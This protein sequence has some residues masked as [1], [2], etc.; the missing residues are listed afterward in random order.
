MAA[1]ERYTAQKVSYILRHNT[2]ENP[3]PSSNIDIDPTRSPLND[4]L[5]PERGT[6]A[7]E[8]KDYYNQRLN[9]IYHM[10]R[11]DIITTCQW[12][13]TA[14]ADLAPEQEQDFF[15]ETYAYLNNL[16]GQKNC[17][18]CV[19]HRDEGIKG[20]NGQIIAGRAHMHYVFLPV[21]ENKKYMKPNKK[22]NVTKKNI[23]H[24]KL[25]ADEL[26]TK[27]HLKSFHPN[28]QKWFNNVGIKATVHS[29]VT[30]GKN[31]IVESLKRETREIER[32]KEIIAALEAKN[33]SLKERILELENELSHNREHERTKP[34][35]WGSRS[36]WGKEISWEKEF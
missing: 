22:G 6:T 11:S 23:F 7:R 30:G 1:L 16:Y 14:P 29:G 26:I 2:R 17:I 34:A 18:Q 32:Q 35:G 15:K 20:K 27:S 21:V 25:C 33:K 4:T 13:I 10:N 9:E 5:A 24:E 8:C 12:V 28:Y 3:K 31:R 36:G 19:V